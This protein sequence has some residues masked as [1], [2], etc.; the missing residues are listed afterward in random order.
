M[1]LCIST[2]KASQ[3]IVYTDSHGHLCQVTIT[4]PTRAEMKN[5][6]KEAKALKA[7]LQAAGYKNVK[8]TTGS[9][10][11]DHRFLSD[12]MRGAD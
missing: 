12:I 6:R 7:E 5:N 1:G 11:I 9:S 8:I 2:P 3:P 10:G 4:E